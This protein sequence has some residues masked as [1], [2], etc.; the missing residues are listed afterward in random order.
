M[1]RCVR[2]RE[3]SPT[4]SRFRT[5][6]PARFCGRPARRSIPFRGRAR[7]STTFSATVEEKSSRR[8]TR[9]FRREAG[10]VTFV[11]S[12]STARRVDRRSGFTAISAKRPIA[13]KF[14]SAKP[15]G[16]ISLW[17]V[18]H[19]GFLRCS[20]SR[21]RTESA[22]SPATFSS[23]AG[24]SGGFDGGGVAQNILEQPFSAQNRRRPVRIGRHHQNPALAKQPFASLVRQVTRRKWLP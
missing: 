5:W 18:A 23:N 22:C 19:A 2:W 10:P 17:H 21:S 14:S 16:S 4:M 15:N 3:S 24:T 1:A 6:L 12:I 9:A 7:R 20:S 11:P 8:S 13:S